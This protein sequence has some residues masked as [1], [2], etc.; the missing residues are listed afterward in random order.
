MIARQLCTFL[1]EH[2]GLRRMFAEC[3]VDMHGEVQW[4][5]FLGMATE[6]LVRGHTLTD[7]TFTASL[8]SSSSSSSSPS[9]AEALAAAAAAMTAASEGVGAGAGTDGDEEKRNETKHMGGETKNESGGDTAFATEPQPRVRFIKKA[10][11]ATSQ[12]QRHAPPPPAAH[13]LSG[14]GESIA[15]AGMPIPARTASGAPP[16]MTEST[17]VGGG[18]TGEVTGGVNGGVTGGVTVLRAAL[19]ALEE[20]SGAGDGGDGSNAAGD[21]PDRPMIEIAMSTSR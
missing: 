3:A 5:E 16:A 13:S 15:M 6:A 12:P 18:L 2:H 11:A 9:A 20:S 17:T 4:D 8:S 7:A 19:A 10:K 14:G 21:D 1:S